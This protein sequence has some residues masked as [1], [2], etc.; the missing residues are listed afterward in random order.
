MFSQ[1]ALKP[2]IKTL[3]F[4]KKKFITNLT[5]INTAIFFSSLSFLI[6]LNNC[7]EKDLL[8]RIYH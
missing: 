3:I 2:K 6:Y 8:T 5:F 4:L 7:N 1:R